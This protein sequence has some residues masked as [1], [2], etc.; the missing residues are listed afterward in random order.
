MCNSKNVE[1]FFCRTK[2]DDN[3]YIATI[4][5]KGKYGGKNICSICLEQK[6][7]EKYETKKLSDILPNTYD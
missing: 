5:H 4:T 7:L 2:P 3:I 6:I 1:C